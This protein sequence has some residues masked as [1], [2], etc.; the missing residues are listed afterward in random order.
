[1]LDLNFF[2]QLEATENQYLFNFIL[3]NVIFLVSYISRKNNK[4]A[5]INWFL[6]LVFCLYAYW[7]TDYFTFA[8]T[9]YSFNKLHGYRDPL[10][11]YLSFF[12]LGSYTLYRLLIWGGALLLYKK[13]LERFNVPLNLSAFIF[14]VFYLLTFS[15][16]RISLGIAIYLYGVSILLNA[17]SYK[18]S[19]YICGVIIVLCSYLG[20]RAMALPILLTPIILLKLNKKYIA[21]IIIC[22]FIL[23]RLSGSLLTQLLAGNILIGSGTSAEEALLAY[24]SNENDVTMNWKFALTSKLRWYSIYILVGYSVWKSFYSSCEHVISENIKR[25][26]TFCLVLFIFSY[27]LLQFD[28]IGA[29]EM[30]ERFLFLLGLPLTVVLT[31][32]TNENICSSRTM[33]LLLSLAFVYAEG[34]MFGKILSFY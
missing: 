17:K 11:Y 14:A 26:V 33:F 10:Y 19:N 16:G 13:S 6:I 22:G 4:T 27:S 1:M 9:F 23:I 21:I 7:D 15:F 2:T 31:Y 25:L 5:I 34:F 18:V 32:F 29:K 3:M 8:Q 12:T 24:A 28:T 30:G 20:H